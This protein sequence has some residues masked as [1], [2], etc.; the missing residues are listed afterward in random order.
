[1]K[2][3]AEQYE[4]NMASL[5]GDIRKWQKE[6]KERQLQRQQQREEQQKKKEIQLAWELWETYKYQSI[7]DYVREV[8]HDYI[9]GEVIDV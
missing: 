8:K 1:M 4:Q 3:T 5:L 9:N 2:K 6:N 7:P